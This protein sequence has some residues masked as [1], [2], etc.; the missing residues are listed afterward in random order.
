MPS[1]KRLVYAARN[2]G[3]GL[4]KIGISIC[5]ATRAKQ[6]AAKA[7]YSVSV[8]GAIK[9][10]FLDERAAHALLRS[11]AE[12]GEWFHPTEEVMAFVRSLPK[13]TGERVVVNLPS[14]AWRKRLMRIIEDKCEEFGIPVVSV[15]Q[16]SGFLGP[17]GKYLSE[18]VIPTHY[19][20]LTYHR[21]LAK[22]CNECRLP[23]LKKMGIF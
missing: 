14:M 22:L 1:A 11:S 6:L 12:G 8:L 4:I 18:K 17:M 20:V 15:A 2:E 5:P 16:D 19:V 7:G 10:D 21:S 13:Y 9:G 23:T 3:T